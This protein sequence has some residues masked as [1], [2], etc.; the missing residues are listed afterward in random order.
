MTLNLPLNREQVYRELDLELPE[1]GDPVVVGGR[2]GVLG[3]TDEEISAVPVVP[4]PAP[5]EPTDPEG[6]GNGNGKPNGQPNGNGNR[7]S[8]SDY[9]ALAAIY[10]KRMGMAGTDL[11]PKKKEKWLNAKLAKLRAARLKAFAP[12]LEKIT[13]L[14]K[15]RDADDFKNHLLDLKSQLTIFAEEAHKNHVPA[16]IVEEMLAEAF[17]NGMLDKFDRQ[18]KI[19][20]S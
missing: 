15:T 18:K 1:E 20:P 3:P 13:A 19:L 2:L 16:Q 8:A 14:E 4:E 10:A 6:N 17:Q 11:E 9:K 12:L 5:N 7:L